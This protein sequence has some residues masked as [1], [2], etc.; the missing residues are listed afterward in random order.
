L[1][2]YDLDSELNKL[3]DTSLLPDPPAVKLSSDLW[4]VLK[5]SQQI[6]RASGGAF[7]VTIGPLTKL[8][9]RARRW[10]ELPDA[11]LLAAAKRSIGY[12]LLEL[13]EAAHAARLLRPK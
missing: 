1:S 8:W 9:R 11:D 7:D 4:L 6:S 2:D 12:Q 10:K 13:D 3:S 5:E